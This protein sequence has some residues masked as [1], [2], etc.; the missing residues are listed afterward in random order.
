MALRLIRGVTHTVTPITLCVVDISFYWHIFGDT[1]E[2]LARNKNQT[3]C[4]AHFCCSL[5]AGEGL[6]AGDGLQLRGGDDR[7]TGHLYVPARH[8]DRKPA[9]ERRA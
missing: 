4:Q 9:V 2:N 3:V 5:F 6:S 1:E 7:W 8:E